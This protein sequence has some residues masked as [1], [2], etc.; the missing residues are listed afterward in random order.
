MKIL[1]LSDLH[2]GKRLKEYSLIE[3][4]RYVL[5][6]AVDL[7]DK[8]GLDAM[9]LCGDIYDS[10]VPSAEATA[11]FDEFLTKVHAKHLPIFIISGNHDSAD[12]L[13]FGSAIFKEEGIHVIT[14]VQDALTPIAFKGINI[15]CL[16]FIRPADV[17]YAFG[18][19][20]KSY[21]EAVQD[22]LKRMAIDPKETNL[23]LAHQT[24]L[25]DKGPLLLGG[26]EEVLS[27]EDGSVVG[28]VSAVSAS[29]FKD[30]DYVALGHIHKPQ[31]V[32]KNARYA[33]SILKYHKDEANNPKSF[34]LLEVS[35]KHV[36]VTPLPIHPLHDV[37]RLEGSLDEILS[38]DVDKNAYL[39]ASLT[40]KTLLDD[41]MAKLKSKYP[42]AAWVDYLSNDVASPDMHIID[43]EHVSKE[44]LF[45]DFYLSQNGVALTSEQET[46]VHSLLNDE[47]DKKA[48]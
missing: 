5:N 3:D 6:Q 28:D 47:E 20:V 17:N 26:S 33:G 36:V 27:A 37:I 16:P 35:P 32:A 7:I 22:V 41:P 10:T 1:Q 21:S 29:L 30:F 12:K 40:D 42:Y 4:Q 38:M 11:L 13:H 34:T 25:P 39:F 8:E 19:D 23:L 44:K 43:V 14:R 31:A 9:F 18:S 45:R 2:L 48:L 46:V 15:Y 24:V